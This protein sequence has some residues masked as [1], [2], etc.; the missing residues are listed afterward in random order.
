MVKDFASNFMVLVVE[1][2]EMK[3]LLVEIQMV[4]S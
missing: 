1:R 2:L 3:M 4:E